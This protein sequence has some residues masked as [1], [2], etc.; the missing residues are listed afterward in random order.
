METILSTTAEAEYSFTY[1]IVAGVLGLIGAIFI[2]VLLWRALRWIP[3]HADVFGTSIEARLV[4]LA[5]A[6]FFF[7]NAVYGAV[8][9]PIRFILGLFWYVPLSV[10]QYALEDKLYVQ[11]LN[12]VI[13]RSSN[14][15]FNLID[16]LPVIDILYA[17]AVW[18]IV[19]QLFQ[20]V[21]AD[22]P[23]A[24]PT[25][26]KLVTLY[27]S[28]A[29]G[30]RKNIL[31]FMIL[32]LGA[33]LSIAAIAAIPWFEETEIPDDLKKGELKARLAVYKITDEQFKTVFPADYGA[34]KDPFAPFETYIGQL[35][36]WDKNTLAPI[37]QSASSKIAT[38]SKPSNA[39]LQLLETKLKELLKSRTDQSNTLLKRQKEQQKALLER[40]KQFVDIVK[41]EQDRLLNTA[42][43]QFE[44]GEGLSRLPAADEIEDNLLS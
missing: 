4:G 39:Q 5:V 26:P 24:G 2:V 13:E 35:A 30:T 34:N 10:D 18:I 31:L 14:T 37:I 21:R 12:N 44:Q 36:S 40:W 3:L 7:P 41:K 6:G 20:L 19:G 32:F 33:Y 11:V 9:E 23:L 15:F 1:L 16:R 27:Q 42:V 17:L 8:V 22:E 43:D 25:R 38:E 28:I 29:P